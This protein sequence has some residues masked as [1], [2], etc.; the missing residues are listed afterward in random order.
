MIRVDVHEP[1]EIVRL[2]DMATEIEVSNWNMEGWAD[3]SYEAEPCY[4]HDSTIYNVERK[5][6]NDLA[7]GLEEIEEQLGRQMDLHGKAHNRL[8]I[9]GMAEPAPKG[10][11]IYRLDRGRANI[12]GKTW[13]D[14]QGAY[15][16]ISNWLAQV[17]KY[18]EVVHTSTYAGTAIAIAARYKA[19]C[20]LE[21]YHKTFHRMFK[22]RNYDK[23]PQAEIILNASGATRFGPSDALRVAQFFG[24]AIRAW[25]ASPEEWMKIPGI[26]RTT[27]INYLRGI[28]RGDV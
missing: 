22:Q 21:E 2:L 24:T 14:R 4:C 28:G 11:V 18:W 17:G 16:S 1:P 6:W 26:G 13:G 10:V 9:E 23:N 7:S 27:A 12:S 3:Y 5:T 25:K 20:V 15:E 19:D 8:L